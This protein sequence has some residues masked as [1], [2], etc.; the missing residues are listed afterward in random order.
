MNFRYKTDLHCQPATTNRVLISDAEGLASTAV[1]ASE[2][3]RQRLHY[4]GEPSD[5]RFSGSQVVL[6]E[7]FPVHK[8]NSR[9]GTRWLCSVHSTSSE[10]QPPGRRFLQMQQHKDA[11]WIFLARAGS[12]GQQNP[13]HSLRQGH[14]PL[15]RKYCHLSLLTSLTMHR[16]GES[17]EVNILKRGN[18]ASTNESGERARQRS[19]VRRP[20]RSPG[21]AACAKH[22]TTVREFIITRNWSGYYTIPT[23]GWGNWGG[24]GTVSCPVRA[25]TVTWCPRV[26]RRLSPTG[27]GVPPLPSIGRA[28]WW[29]T[30]LQPAASADAL[31]ED[32]QSLVPSLGSVSAASPHLRARSQT[33]CHPM[34][35]APRPPT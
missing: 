25:A 30:A 9:G 20:Q 17:L 5:S 4:A 33:T 23:S 29:R 13:V 15:H 2:R 26:T 35:T 6:S 24:A 1:S 3:H 28:S 34:L 12:L 10:L 16:A 14:F 22:H 31:C 27:P 32:A 19:F 18:T 7:E 21:I 11:L 8:R